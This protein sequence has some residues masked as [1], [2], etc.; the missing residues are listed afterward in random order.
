MVMFMF[1]AKDSQTQGV[2]LHVEG[3]SYS[4]DSVMLD[5]QT[6]MVPLTHTTC[7]TRKH[8][9][10]A[11]IQPAVIKA[12]FKQDDLDLDAAMARLNVGADKSGQRFA[13]ALKVK[14]PNIEGR[15]A[16]PSA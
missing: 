6:K 10:E 11:H 5:V 15:L 1:V 4:G 2:S 7:S 3:L 9:N 13:K 8:I 12:G 16:G 14:A